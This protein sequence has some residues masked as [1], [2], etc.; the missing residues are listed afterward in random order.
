MPEIRS[1]RR[2]RIL[3]TEDAALS[4]GDIVYDA[5]GN[6]YEFTGEDEVEEEVEREPQPVGKS[7][8]FEPTHRDEADVRQAVMDELSKAFTDD[9]RDKVIAKAL[10]R[11]ARSWRPSRTQFEQIA[12]AERDLRLTREYISKAAEYNLPVDPERAGPGALPD[13]RD[14]VLRRLRGDRQVPGDGW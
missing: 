8:F 14:D 3:L 2:G 5:E 11:G 13:G 12:K 7:A 4:D 1:V 10:G 9:D 6:A